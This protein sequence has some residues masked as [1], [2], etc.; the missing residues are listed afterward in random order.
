[1]FSILAH[2]QEA[3]AGAPKPSA[4][5]QFMPFIFIFIIFYFFLIRPQQR[6]AKTHQEFVSG[7]KKGDS[8]LTTGGI[9]GT[10]EGLT[11]QF[12]TLEIAQDVRIRILRSQVA[13]PQ[14]Q[15]EEVVSVSAKKVKR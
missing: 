8:V 13:S 9:L 7:L 10:I 15:K 4:L 11:E 1:M 3:A 14:G 2:A 5:E 6:K 12:V